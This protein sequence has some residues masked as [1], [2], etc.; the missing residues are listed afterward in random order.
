MREPLPSS[1]LHECLHSWMS[2]R[3]PVLFS[4]KTKETPELFYLCSRC[5]SQQFNATAHPCRAVVRGLP[6]LGKVLEF[7]TPEYGETLPKVCV[8]MKGFRDG[9][10]VLFQRAWMHLVLSIS[11]CPFGG[12][13]VSP[14]FRLSDPQVWA[15][16]DFLCVGAI[17]FSSL[18]IPPALMQSLPFPRSLCA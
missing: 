10:V 2:T 18:I 7:Y 1:R 8:H 5:L 14:R 11:E 4:T 13:P 15:V 9:D 12:L 16:C 6:F 3:A 17:A